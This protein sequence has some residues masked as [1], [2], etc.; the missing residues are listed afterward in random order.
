MTA[1]QLKNILSIIPDDVEV[2]ADT[3]WECG[4]VPLGKGYLIKNKL[5]FIQDGYESQEREYEAK[6]KA[7]QPKCIDLPKVSIRGASEPGQEMSETVHEVVAEMEYK[8]EIGAIIALLRKLLMATWD[9][10]IA[11]RKHI[12]VLVEDVL[13][14]LIDA[15][16]ER[17]KKEKQEDEKNA[18]DNP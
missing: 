17:L 11:H 8:F 6:L 3:G 10:N 4:P 15:M 5:I 7:E 13:N 1:G 14:F 2:E 12:G 16:E 9:F 18:D